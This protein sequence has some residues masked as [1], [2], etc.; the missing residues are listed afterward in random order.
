MRLEVAL[1]VLLAG[2][3]CAG[4]EWRPETTSVLSV[5]LVRWP[6]AAELEPFET[7]G[8]QDHALLD[9]LRARGVPPARVLALHDSQATR[10][11]V[12]RA[13]AKVC[14]TGAR[15]DTLI[16][17]LQAHG[18]K[19]DGAVA[20][21][22][23]DVDQERPLETGLPIADVAR[24]IAARWRGD[25]VFLLGD[26]CYSGAL[27]EAARTLNATGRMR[28][29][30]LAASAP[31]DTSTGRWTFTETIVRALRGDALCDGDRDG[32]ITVGE[33]AARVQQVMKHREEQLAGIELDTRAP[34]ELVL[35]RV[36]PAT[37]PA[38]APGRWQVGDGVEARDRL[39]DWYTA[40]VLAVDGAR[41]QVRYA[42]WGPEDDEW[43]AADHLRALAPSAIR[44]GDRVR[45]DTDGDA[46]RE[47]RVLAVREG[48]FCFVHYAGEDAGSDEWVPVRR[49]TAAPSR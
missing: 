14:A 10:P 27:A 23:W 11:G 28:A 48:T 40:E 22:T 25:T 3:A 26:F 19:D 7:D 6:R 5:S 20:L 8:R 31:S 41:Y 12:T 42:G 16:V 45:V 46:P 39:G 13:L 21:A 30:A 18:I 9:A 29:V 35:A 34:V 32:A 37:R 36:D 1:T 4:P 43:V 49:L 24:T 15:G 47:A 17:Y 38:R 2:A 44:A 33:V